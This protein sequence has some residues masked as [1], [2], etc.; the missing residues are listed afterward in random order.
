MSRLALVAPVAL[1]I[2]ALAGCQSEEEKRLEQEK[3]K[4]EL[5]SSILND[6]QSQVP[7]IVAVEFQRALDDHK[8]KLAD[9]AAKAAAAKAA[10]PAAAKGA[11]AGSKPSKTPAKKK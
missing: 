1:A 7:G 8:R 4:A 3:L 9:E 5:R 2:F 10:Q 11:A 6:L